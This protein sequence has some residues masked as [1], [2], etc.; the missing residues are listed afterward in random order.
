MDPL[1]Q[2]AELNQFLDM[3]TVRTLDM[4]VAKVGFHGISSYDGTVVYVAAGGAD[5]ITVPHEMENNI[6]RY[7]EPEA[8]VQARLISPQKDKSL[9]IDGVQ[10]ESGF[11][12]EHRF[13]KNYPEELPTSVPDELISPF[14]ARWNRRA[15]R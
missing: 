8:A 14:S 1:L 6:R 13:Q 5:S 9:K 2:G 3:V 15:F 11:V 12:S 7:V 10:C 4:N